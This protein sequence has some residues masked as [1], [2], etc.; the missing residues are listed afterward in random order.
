MYSLLLYYY[1]K[2]PKTT[3]SCEE[4]IQFILVYSSRGRVHKGRKGMAARVASAGKQA[5]TSTTPNLKK[6]K[7][8]GSEARL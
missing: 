1:D 2:T 7:Q 5:I 6:S 4:K 8:S 3:V